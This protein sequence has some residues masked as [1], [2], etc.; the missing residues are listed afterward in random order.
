[1][2]FSL[3]SLSSREIVRRLSEFEPDAGMTYIDGELF[4]GEVRTVPLY[5]EH[6]LLLTPAGSP[7]AKCTRAEWAAVAE[8]PLCLLT[9][10]MQNRADPRPR[11]RRC[12]GHRFAEAGGRVS[13]GGA[14]LLAGG[15]VQVPQPVDPEPDQHP[16]HPGG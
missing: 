13:A 4:G 6:Y 12:R 2:R 10:V 15:R 9:P 8:L 5:R 11:L 1:M 16:V 14:Q 3:E 7:L